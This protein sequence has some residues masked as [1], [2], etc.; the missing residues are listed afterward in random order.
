[1]VDTPYPFPLILINPP[2][3]KYSHNVVLGVVNTGGGILGGGD[4]IVLTKVSCKLNVCRG[5]LGRCWPSLSLETRSKYP[6]RGLGFNRLQELI[7]PRV[8]TCHQADLRPR[9]PDKPQ[10]PLQYE[11]PGAFP[12][13]FPLFICIVIFPHKRLDNPSFYPMSYNYA[14]HITV[15][16]SI[17]FRFASATWGGCSPYPYVTLCDPFPKA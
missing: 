8:C 4:C 12:F 5:I 13:G 6:C 17:G 14:S 3:I 9:I 16:T 2:D 15:S 11:Y 1:M 7:C 10:L